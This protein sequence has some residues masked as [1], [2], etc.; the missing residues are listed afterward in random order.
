MKPL[1]RIKVIGY[2]LDQLINKLQSK[3]ILM[4]NI[5]RVEN[6]V[7]FFSVKLRQYK[8]IKI[9]PCFTLRRYFL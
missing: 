5:E 3:N 4:Y 6:N 7:M 1:V 8:S 9:P 2:N